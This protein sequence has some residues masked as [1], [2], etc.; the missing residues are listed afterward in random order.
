M[1]HRNKYKNHRTAFAES[2]RGQKELSDMR[3]MLT[4]QFARLLD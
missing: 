2:T 4:M 3:L 1:H